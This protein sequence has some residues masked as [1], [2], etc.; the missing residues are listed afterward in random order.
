MNTMET[1]NAF[2][3][4]AAIKTTIRELLSSPYVEEEGNFNHILSPWQGKIIR[5]SLLATIVEKEMYGT[6]TNILV[7][8]GTGKIIV[9]F[10][11]GNPLAHNLNL[12]EVI[13][14]IGKLR[15]YNQEKYISPE[16]VKKMP[17]A[18]LKV[19]ALELK[20]GLTAKV[21]PP[22]IDSMNKENPQMIEEIA[23]TDEPLLPRQKI[24]Q[25]IKE[26]DDGKGVLIEDL[27]EKSPI[28]E[29]E[30]VLGQMLESGEIF[31]ILP[32][33]VKVL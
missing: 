15:K 33:K 11:E 18:W 31:Q 24:A 17:A 4:F 5:L 23:I 22:A 14:I 9:R 21:P 32:G 10:F 7:D 8:D 16:I 25:L 29:T 13:L 28:Q 3:R 30:Q 12:G 2:V 26:M 6:I 1:N 20:S 19:R 27:L